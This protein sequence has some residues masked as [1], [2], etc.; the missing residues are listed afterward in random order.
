MSKRAEDRI[1][2]CIRM[3][4]ENDFTAVPKKF[5][6]LPSRDIAIDGVKVSMHIKLR[7]AG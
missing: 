3:L 2:E 5:D 6:F 7:K 4:I 1:F